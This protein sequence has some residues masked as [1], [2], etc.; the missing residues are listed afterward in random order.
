VFRTIG[1]FFPK[2]PGLLNC[3]KVAGVKHPIVFYNAPFEQ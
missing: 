2:I 1:C 3:T